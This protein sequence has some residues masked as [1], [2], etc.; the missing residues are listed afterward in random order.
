M[1]KSCV[2]LLT[3]NNK[4]RLTGKRSINEPPFDYTTNCA[5]GYWS[6]VC[7]TTPTFP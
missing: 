1:Y 7:G 4:V 3:I 5:E 2:V 6:G